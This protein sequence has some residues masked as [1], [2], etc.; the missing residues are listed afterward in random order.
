MESRWTSGAYRPRR[1]EAVER[2]LR[3]V[4]E[5]PREL[6]GRLVRMSPNPPEPVG[7]DHE[8]FAGAGMGHAVRLEEGRALEYRNRW[9]RTPE[10]SRAL[11][12]T[13]ICDPLPFFDVANTHVIP[14]RGEL[15]AMTETCMPYR[16]DL[17]LETLGREDFGAIER[18]TAH[19]HVDPVTGELHAVGYAID[20]QPLATYWIIDADGKAR[21][22]RDIVLSESAFMHDFAL[23]QNH[24]ILYDLP[25]RFHA[26]DF[27][28]GKAAPYRWDGSSPARVGI[29]RRDRLDA[30]IDWIEIEP[31]WVFHTLNAY[32]APDGRIVLDLI[33]FERFFDTDRTGPGD[34]WPPTLHRFTIDAARTRVTVECVDDRIQEFPR[35]D[36]RYFT[37]P[38][39]FGFTSQ[40]F[41]PEGRSGVLM[42][43]FTGP[44]SARWLTEPGER[45]SEVVFVPRSEQAGEGE[46]W[47]LG[48]KTSEKAPNSELLVFEAEALAEGPVARVEIPHRIPVDVHG[49]WVPAEPTARGGAR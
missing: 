37:R 20:D 24:V 1:D 49:S 46:G 34:P 22:K 2:D 42:H 27:A 4:G 33:R 3:V 29:L 23:T 10:V 11:G 9:V 15:L 38:H 8:W 7:P 47:L 28:S 21:E 18:F 14:F 40:L 36:E 6:N 45:I 30:P 48:L 13:P 12:E 41:D 39:R 43:D 17:D 25:I 32:D 26:G 44:D 31:C 16:L 35:L 19:P 5:L